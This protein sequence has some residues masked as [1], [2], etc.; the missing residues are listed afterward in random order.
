M[1]PLKVDTEQP[2]MGLAGT[3]GENEDTD[4][5]ILSGSMVLMAMCS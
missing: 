3:R 1:L 2:K 4:Q 5:K